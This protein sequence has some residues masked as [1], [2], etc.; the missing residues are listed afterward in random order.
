[1]FSFL[2]R[3]FTC[4]KHSDLLILM[5]ITI[6]STFASS[7]ISSFL[8]C[9]FVGLNSLSIYIASSSSLL[10]RFA[11]HLCFAAV[12]QGRSNH[13]L[14][15][16]DLHCR[17]NF[18]VTND[19]SQKIIFNVQVTTRDDVHHLMHVNLYVVLGCG[20]GGMWG[21]AVGDMMQYGMLCRRG[22][23]TWGN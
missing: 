17:L 1:M 6:G 13:C 18:L 2:T 14:V 22:S 21:S 23:S 4:P 10:L 5:T 20:V 8:Q 3:L 16:Q 12:K 7:K 11:F 19:W 9:F 15:Y